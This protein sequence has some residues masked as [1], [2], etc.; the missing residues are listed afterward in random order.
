MHL[1]FFLLMNEF[2]YEKLPKFS[3][4]LFFSFVSFSSLMR[5]CKRI[6]SKPEARL[7]LSN[8]HCRKQDG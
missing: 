2:R 7:Q 3:L 5:K 8:L 1:E 6:N 4:F